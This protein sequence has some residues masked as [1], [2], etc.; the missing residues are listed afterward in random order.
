MLEKEIKILDVD[1][2]KLQKKLEELWAK[3]TFEW[4]IHDIYYDFPD[5]GKH[6]MEANKRIFR[7]RKKWDIH[8]YTI[9]RK[10]TDKNEWWEKWVKVADEWE[11]EITDVDSFT[12]VL[13][14]YGM[15]AIR[16]KKKYRISYALDWIEFD[17]D[18]YF[19]QE[20]RSL[21]PPLL[22]IEAS[23]KDEIKN[24][25]KKLWLENHKQVDWGSKKLFK[26]YWVDYSWL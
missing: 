11:R 5:D 19:W 23:S 7:V 21:I 18:D 2:E 26:N 14:K 12:K 8:M 4:Y 3:K 25:I 15:K 9:K 24:W 16:E 17:I 13:E 10:R 22:E 6:K 20:D 1:V